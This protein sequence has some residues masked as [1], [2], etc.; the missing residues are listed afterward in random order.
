[1]GEKIG[2]GDLGVPT[3]SGSGTPSITLF[4]VVGLLLA[5]GEP[6]RGLN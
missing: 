2:W 4:F 1:M 3:R 6:V 5:G